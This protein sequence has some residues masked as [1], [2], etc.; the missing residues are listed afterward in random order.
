[1]QMVSF[2]VQEMSKP[3]FWNM[4]TKQKNQSVVC[5]NNFPS[6]DDYVPYNII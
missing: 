5:C 3:V 6:I 1:M 4:K 2:N